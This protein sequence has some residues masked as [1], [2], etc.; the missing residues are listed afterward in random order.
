MI[1]NIANFMFFRIRNP[2]KVLLKTPATA[3]AVYSIPLLVPENLVPYKSPT[4]DRYNVN[5]EPP[6]NPTSI[7][8]IGNEISESIEDIKDRVFS[9][10]MLLNLFNLS[11]IIPKS[12]L[13]TPLIIGNSVIANKSSHLGNLEP[14]KDKDEENERR[15]IIAKTYEK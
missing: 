13:P 1:N 5:V 6:N 9:K 12:G 8:E 11:E 15:G 4:K 2:N 10:I 7:A 3:F 14:K